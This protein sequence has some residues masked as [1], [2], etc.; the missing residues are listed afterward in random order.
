MGGAGGEAKAKDISLLNNTTLTWTTTSTSPNGVVRSYPHL[1]TD[2]DLQ[3]NGGYYWTYE[4]SP[5]LDFT[6]YSRLTIQ[7]TCRINAS[8]GST[9]ANIAILDDSDNVVATLYTA[10]TPNQTWTV[11]VDLDISSY[12]GNFKL[13]FSGFTINTYSGI[14]AYTSYHTTECKLYAA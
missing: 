7:G 4:T 8:T 6:K 2:M 13:R 5:L 11:N 3:S 10:S 1:I 12:T 9:S 14:N